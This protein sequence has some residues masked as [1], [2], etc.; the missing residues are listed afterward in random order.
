MNYPEEVTVILNLTL[1]EGYVVEST[2]NPI[3]F[4]TENNGIQAS[5][6]SSQTPGK[7]NVTM[8]YTLKQLE[9]DPVEY[10][11]LKNFYNERHQKFNEQI[12]LT[13]S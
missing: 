2:P 9:F 4:V 1:P 13:K 5:Y 7:L 3:K 10:T 8:K 11:A 6:N 12:V